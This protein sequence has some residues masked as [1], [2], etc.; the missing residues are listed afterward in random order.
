M[1]GV[2]S[3]VLEAYNDRISCSSTQTPQCYSGK[4]RLDHLENS[5]FILRNL[6]IFIISI[7]SND[8]EK[9]DNV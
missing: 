1:E 5:W 9:V 7:D 6:I 2:G 3:S 8:D 4:S